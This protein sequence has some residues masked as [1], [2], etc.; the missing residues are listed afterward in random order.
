[1]SCR[2][3][4]LASFRKSV[5]TTTTT[6][7][8]TSCSLL[9]I[10]SN[11]TARITGASS[12]TQLLPLLPLLKTSPR[13]S[14]SDEASSAAAAV[15]KKKT[16]KKKKS[17]D[18]ST[19]TASS[20]GRDKTLDLVLR[21]LDAPYSK[22]P[23]DGISPEERQRRYEIGRNYVIGKFERHNREQHDLNCKLQMKNHA[24]KLLPRNN[25][26]LKQAALE[27]TWD[28]PPLWRRIPVDTPPI[29]GFD[30]TK[31]EITD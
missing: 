25:S 16:K 2:L 28:T 23:L 20:G 12:S 8:T 27:E 13:R 29:P 9:S 31:Y 10:G 6:T 19:T 4:L 17:S 22:E 11:A 1:M 5:A 24:I 18:L 30:P 26:K 21:A 15:A 3:L 14:M 7:T